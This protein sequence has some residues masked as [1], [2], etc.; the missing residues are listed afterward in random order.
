[1]NS[2]RG[3]KAGKG[4]KRKEVMEIIRKPHFL[5]LQRPKSAAEIEEIA[6]RKIT[7]WLN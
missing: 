6:E 4:K 5:M 7:D 3:E 2:K 1:L